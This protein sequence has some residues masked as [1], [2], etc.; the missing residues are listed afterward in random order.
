MGSENR[1]GLE[2]HEAASGMGFKEPIDRYKAAGNNRL[3]LILWRILDKGLGHQIIQLGLDVIMV[4][5]GM[6]CGA[7]VGIE[8]IGIGEELRNYIFSIFIC[9]LG[10]TIFSYTMG[11]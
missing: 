2:G 6:I 11:G 10:V 8:L 4:V 7:L 3:L 1:K 5:S 9:V